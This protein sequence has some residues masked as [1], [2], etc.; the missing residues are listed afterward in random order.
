MG[1]FTKVFLKDKRIENIKA[2]NE[3]L[4][5]LELSKDYHFYSED[6]ILLEYEAFKNSDGVFPEHLFP[7]AKIKSY[8]DFIK[9]WNTKSL[10]EMFCPHFGSLTFD[11]Y[12]G[13]MSDEDMAKVG[14]FIAKN[15][16]IFEKAYGSFTTFMER[17]MTEEKRKIIKQSNIIIR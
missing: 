17:G 12:F 10:G 14:K 11:C 1:G 4:K 5:K 13:R 8:N 3:E 2:Q 15:V 9:F 7:K 16:D 6:D